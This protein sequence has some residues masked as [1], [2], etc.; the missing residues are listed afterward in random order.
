MVAKKRWIGAGLLLALVSSAAIAAV[1]AANISSSPGLVIQFLNQTVNLYRETTI[2]ERA[3]TQPE[4]QVLLYDNARIASQFVQLAF[5]FA[6][7]QANA[8]AAETASNA[9]NAS[10]SA[11]NSS[12]LGKMLVALDKL[13]TSTR[14]ESAADQKKLATA[15]GAERTRLQSTISELQGEISLARAR[16]DAVR[17][18]VEFQSGSGTQGLGASGLKAQIDALAA[19]VPVASANA[20]GSTS[21]SRNAPTLPA[22]PTGAPPGPSGIWNL[23]SNL[24][25]LSSKMGVID[26]MIAD[27]NGLLSTSDQLRSPFITQLRTLTSQGNQIAIRADTATPAQL[28]VEKQQLD[29]IAAQFKELAASVTPLGKQ[30]VLLTVYLKNLQSWRD[31]V[32]AAY[33][34]DLRSLGIRLGLLALLIAVLYGL[35]EIWRRAV[36]RY[37]Q[38]VRRRHQ[39]LLLRKLTLWFVIVLIVG[40]TLAGQLSSFATFAGLLTAGVAVALQNVISSV[41]GYFF[42]IGKFGIRV[43]DRVEVTGIRG[44]VIDIGL[45]RFHVME[46]GDGATPTGR[47]VA[48]SNSVVFQPSAGLFKQ[49]PGASFAWHQVTL[50]VPR[51]ADFPTIKKNLLG[52]VENAIHDY[53]AEINRLYGEMEKRGILFSERELQPRLELSLKP[54][55]IE[56]TI[57]YPVDLPHATDIDARVSHELLTALERDAKLQTPQGPEIHLKT[58]VPAGAAG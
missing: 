25:A 35:S 23:A 5:T 22:E 15:R 40:L 4:E 42:L 44:E 54:T 30:R 12:A 16:R 20:A 46:L 1:R 11:A 38:D 41:V 36:Y 57:R 13:L 28:A 7:D 8:M 34:A 53:R 14:A 2:Q 32:G 21:P 29:G 9:A 18:L 45:V 3:A 58:D 55:A 43:G 33:R 6:R 51:E 47:V 24:F 10:A 50:T 17:N 26:S 56:V 49:I 48:F 52:A 39:F 31:S 19:S 27:T 37:V